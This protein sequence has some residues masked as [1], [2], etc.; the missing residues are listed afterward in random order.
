MGDARRLDARKN[1][2]H[3][4]IWKNPSNLEFYTRPGSLMA[5]PSRLAA[6]NR[7]RCSIF[8]TSYNPTGLRTGAK[9]LSARRRGPSLIK[10]YPQKLDLAR[11]MREFPELEFVEP[12]E[13][14]RLVDIEERRKRGKGTPRKAKDKSDYPLLSARIWYSFS[15]TAESRR[16]H[17]KR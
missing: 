12:K 8:Q 15:P 4:R 13:E 3:P 16:A 10:Y 7:L 6:L 2:A 9:Y 17:R 1:D 14:Q 11:I 5:S